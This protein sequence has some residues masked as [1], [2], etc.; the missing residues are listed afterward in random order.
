MNALPSIAEPHG[1]LREFVQGQSDA[2]DVAAQYECFVDAL[3]T[4]SEAANLKRLWQSYERH[5]R[6]N[7]EIWSQ[8]G[9]IQTAKGLM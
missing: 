6:K 1:F 5:F 9:D 2:L 3:Q 4:A 8:C 7:I